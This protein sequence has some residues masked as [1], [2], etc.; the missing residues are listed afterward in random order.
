[1][2]FLSLLKSQP[3]CPTFATPTND[4]G[5]QYHDN[6]WHNMRVKRIGNRGYIKIDF[7]WIGDFSFSTV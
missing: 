2:D 6:Q 1:M 3:D 4:E 5:L 7:R